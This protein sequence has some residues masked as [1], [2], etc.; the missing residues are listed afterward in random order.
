MLKVTVRGDSVEDEG[1]TREI[2][3]YGQFDIMADDG[4]ALFTLRLRED[5]SLEIETG[6]MAVKYGG[7]VLDSSFYMRPSGGRIT[8]ARDEYKP[9][10]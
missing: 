8:V 9:E 6:L 10:V 4:R 3:F 7:R 1:A 2:A 5:G